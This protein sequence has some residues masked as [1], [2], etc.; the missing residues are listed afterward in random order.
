[1]MTIDRIAYSVK[2]KPGEPPLA[3]LAPVPK[4]IQASP[5]SALLETEVTGAQLVHQFENAPTTACDAGQWVIRYDDGQTGLFREQLVYIAQQ[6]AAPCE[7]NTALGN[8]GPELRRSLFEGL[9][10]G[11]HN[12]LERLLQRFQYLVTVEGEAARHALGEIA[13]FD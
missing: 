11:A 13:P 6:R 9:L 10:D 3:E 1:M 8:V 12:A 2:R 7:H 4:A 5:R